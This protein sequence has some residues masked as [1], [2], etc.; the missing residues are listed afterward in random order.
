MTLDVLGRPD[1]ALGW[2]GLARELGGRSSDEYGLIGDCWVR[3]G[4]DEKAVQAYNRAVELQPDSPQGGIGICHLRLLQG[5]YQGA[6]ELYQTSRWS[7]AGLGEG[8]QIAAQIE[9]FARSFDAAEKLYADLLQRDINGGG[10]FYGAISYQSALGRI[11]QALG[12]STGAK[13]LLERC[14]EA[15]AVAVKRTPTNPEALYRLAAVEST[16]GMST[17]SIDHLR[18]AV[19]SG[20]IDYRSLA[21]DPRFDT[22][23]ENLQFRTILEDL[24]S[25]VADMRAKMRNTSHTNIEE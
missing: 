7:H 9:F 14:L 22:V 20:W 21:M 15:E 6:R 19:S 12:E 10:S 8:E 11:R 24:M 3:L 16:L 2:H 13:M 25:N 17:P 5:D 23:R 18:A 4:D 1:R